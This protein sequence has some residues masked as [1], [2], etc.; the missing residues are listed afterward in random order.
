[1]TVSSTG[2][3]DVLERGTGAHTQLAAP[4]SEHSQCTSLSFCPPLILTPSTLL[5]EALFFF[6]M[7][8][9]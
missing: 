3:G 2:E 4:P 1:M 9:V 6:T 8:K 7:Q 5:E